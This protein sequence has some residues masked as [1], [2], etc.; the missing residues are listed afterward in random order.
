[1]KLNSKIK[2]NWFE[3][4]TVKTKLMITMLVLTVIIG[5]ILT[6]AAALIASDALEKTEIEKLYT[7][8]AG[9]SDKLTLFINT[10]KNLAVAF[11]LDYEVHQLLDRMEEGTD[12][13]AQQTHVSNYFASFIDAVDLSFTALNLYDLN[14]VILASNNPLVIGRDDSDRPYINYQKTEGHISKPARGTGSVPMLP[15]GQPVYNEMGQQIG[16]IAFGIQFESFA[17]GVFSTVGLS[18]SS[19]SFLVDS[20]GT[21][22]SSLQGDYSQFDIE[23]FDKSIFPPGKDI[24]IAPE[25]L[26]NEVYATITPVSGT[27]WA[28]IT[29][30]KTAEVEGPIRVLLIIMGLFLFLSILIGLFLSITFANALSTPVLALNECAKNLAVGNIKNANIAH[31]GVDE[32]GQLAEAFRAVSTNSTSR[33]DSLK[34][35]AK[36]NIEFRVISSSD[37]DE[38]G[39]ALIELKRNLGEIV[40]ALQTIAE[41]SAAG[42]LLYRADATKH[43]GAF[44]ELIEALN[45]A[46]DSIVTPVYESIRLSAEYSKGNYSDRFNPGLPVEGEFVQFK[47]ALNQV[48]VG[49]SKA[50]LA[51]R[52]SAHDI[53]ADASDTF[54]SLNALVAFAADLTESAGRVSGFSNRNDIGLEL[55][56]GAMNDLSNA[57]GD[58]AYRT[59]NTSD[60]ATRSSTLAHEGAKCAEMAGEGMEKILKSFATTAESISAI[61]N[62]MEEIGEI[63]GVISGIADQT[64]LLALNAA[65][66]AARAGEVGLGFTVVANEVKAL[67][68]ESQVSAEHIEKIITNLQNLTV[69]MTYKV[70]EAG[71]VLQ[72]G[73][74]SVKEAISAFHQM[75]GAIFDVSK[76]MSAIAAASEEQAAAVQE[77]AASVSE[78]RSMVQNTAAEAIASAQATA[79]MNVSLNQ[80]ERNVAESK[81]LTESIVRQVNEFKID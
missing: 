1:M 7:S 16:L 37:E 41:R 79:D 57:V 5:V 13:T 69:E 40:Q 35:I 51:I 14:G 76:N 30:E 80:I 75:D 66:E 49:S 67:A 77:I 25:F 39:L 15:F 3:F 31:V 45:E 20:D 23:K 12:I 42:D 54:T 68:Q 9:T 22:L 50:L 19:T 26:G 29:T 18:S 61:S 33:V 81:R 64:N 10:G 60:L 43:S 65:L 8:G 44:R 53:S 59:T 62:K 78:V 72:S 74:S 71:H 17:E 58:V 55:V 24:A 56:L 70:G 28:I 34:K 63:V 32:I 46:L 27:D 4:K 6:G 36:G 48:G 21:I 11:A 38:E 47:N 73:N 2:K 52:G